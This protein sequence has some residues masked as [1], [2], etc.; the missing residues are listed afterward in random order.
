MGS[1]E[2]L[3]RPYYV[4]TFM[5]NSVYA[6]CYTIV[7]DPD[8]FR[9]R[10]TMILNYGMKWGFQYASRTQAGVYKYDLREIELKT[11]KDVK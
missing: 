3:N 4:F 9:A 10:R 6:R 1:V 7:N 8:W 5:N 11:G 2:S